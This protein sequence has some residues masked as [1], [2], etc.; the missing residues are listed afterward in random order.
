[1]P[2]ADSHLELAEDLQNTI[3]FLKTKH[4]DHAPWIATTAMYQA[5]HLIEALFFHDPAIH[6]GNDHKTRHDLLK[7]GWYQELWMHYRPLVEASYIARYLH[8]SGTNP[9]QAYNRFSDYMSPEKVVKHLLEVKLAEVDRLVRE[10]LSGLR[11][12]TQSQR[13]V[14]SVSE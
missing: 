5:L 10:R 12:P 11:K 9:D 6:H 7:R 1:M 13:A 3:S 8:R 14:H 2:T 4:T